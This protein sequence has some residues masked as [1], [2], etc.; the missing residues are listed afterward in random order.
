MCLKLGFSSVPGFRD[1][2]ILILKLHFHEFVE[3]INDIF[4]TKLFFTYVLFTF[5]HKIELYLMCEKHA[6]LMLEN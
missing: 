5:S 3:K 4:K 6:M 1:P 2:G